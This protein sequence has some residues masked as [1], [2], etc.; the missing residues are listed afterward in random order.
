M[1]APWLR[2]SRWGWFAIVGA[3]LAR[4]D[5][6]AGG[7]HPPPEPPADAA[8]ADAAKDGAMSDLDAAQRPIDDAALE[9]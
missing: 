4:R 6:C 8:P 1:R 9:A 7:G 5:M 3:L 2:C